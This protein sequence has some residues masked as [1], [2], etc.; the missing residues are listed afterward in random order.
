M[1]ENLAMHNHL[2]W[3]KKTWSLIQIQF[4]SVSDQGN[5][6]IRSVTTDHSD[7]KLVSTY[8]QFK[9][10]SC[11]TFYGKWQHAQ[12]SCLWKMRFKMKPAFKLTFLATFFLSPETIYAT[13]SIFLC[14][15]AVNSFRSVKRKFVY[16]INS[17]SHFISLSSWKHKRALLM[18]MHGNLYSWTGWAARSH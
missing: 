3:W 2:R 1:S 17:L 13:N 11:A 12:H 6:Q 9:W 15:S 10:I 5:A 4:V 16:H 18:K 14:N 8:L 7:R